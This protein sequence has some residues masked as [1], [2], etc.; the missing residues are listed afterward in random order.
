MIHKKA[1]CSDMDRRA[2]KTEVDS[3]I[4]TQM[5]DV[6]AIIQTKSEVGEVKV[7]MDGSAGG[8]GK[9]YGPDSN[10]DLGSAVLMVQQHQFH[11]PCMYGSDS[12]RGQR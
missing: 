10:G 9:I 2:L 11:V 12:Q 7:R 6:L 5:S 1:D 3:A 4:R 8:Y